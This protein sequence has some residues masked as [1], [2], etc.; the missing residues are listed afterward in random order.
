M[1]EL[2]SSVCEE[3]SVEPACTTSLSVLLEPTSSCNLD[4]RYCYKGEKLNRV[5]SL[6]TFEIAA[7]KLS[8]TLVAIIG[9]FSLS[10]TAASRLLPALIF[11]GRHSATVL[12]TAAATRQ[13]TRFRP[14]EHYS[15]T[16]FLT[17]LQTT[18]SPQV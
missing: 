10:G 3:V 17:F 5:M 11:T 16:N 13:P 18:K 9:H 8:H 12:S 1:A 4:C 6:V 2:Q 7:Q 14:M 15:A